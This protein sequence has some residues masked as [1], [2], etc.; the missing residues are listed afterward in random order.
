MTLTLP[1]SAFVIDSRKKSRKSFIFK[2]ILGIRMPHHSLAREGSSRG[3]N[4][5]PSSGQQAS[6]ATEGDKPDQKMPDKNEP[7]LVPILQTLDT[8][9]MDVTRISTLSDEPGAFILDMKPTHCPP[10]LKKTS[11]SL[12]VARRGTAHVILPAGRTALDPRLEERITRIQSDLTPHLAIQAQINA[13]TRQLPHD[14]KNI[15]TNLYQNP[16][17]VYIVRK[18]ARLPE[19]ALSQ[20]GF[21]SNSQGP[22]GWFNFCYTGQEKPELA[23]QLSFWPQKGGLLTNVPEPP[24]NE[25]IINRFLDSA[26]ECSQTIP[27]VHR[28]ARTA[29]DPAATARTLFHY[30]GLI[31]CAAITV[32]NGAKIKGAMVY[33]KDGYSGHLA[34]LYLNHT[35]WTAINKHPLSLRLRGGRETRHNILANNPSAFT[36]M[37][38][39]LNFFLQSTDWFNRRPKVDLHRYTF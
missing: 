21:S 20:L 29:D 37:L 7:W 23:V 22:Y 26:S 33:S 14:Q 31:T 24:R 13:L 8:D 3:R 34:K 19:I 39:D 5:L 11:L 1:F 10:R 36:D 17:A 25:A 27:F 28:L 2:A 18:L 30:P 16:W 32:Q 12:E 38:S 35:G 4:Y 6:L 9:H 15:F